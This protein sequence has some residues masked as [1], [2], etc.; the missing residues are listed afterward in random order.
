[1]AEDDNQVTNNLIFM[2][3]YFSHRSGCVTLLLAL[4]WLGFLLLGTHQLWVAFII[5]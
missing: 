5:N 4:Q 1:M 2:V 3:R